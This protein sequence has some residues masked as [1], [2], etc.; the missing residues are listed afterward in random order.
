MS[1]ELKKTEDAGDDQYYV[2]IL[3]MGASQLSC[4]PEMKISN[5]AVPK[6]QRQL[7]RFF[8]VKK[9]GKSGKSFFLGS[10]DQNEILNFLDFFNFFIYGQYFL[11]KPSFPSSQPSKTLKIKTARSKSTGGLIQKPFGP[12]GASFS[13]IPSPKFQFFDLCFLYFAILGPL[14]ACFDKLDRQKIKN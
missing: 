1:Y 3:Y 2:S 5:R 9:L 6:I 12:P 11:Y 14:K 8:F 10:W 13:P 7:T 4:G